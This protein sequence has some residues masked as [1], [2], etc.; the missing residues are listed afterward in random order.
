EERDFIKDG[1]W[2]AGHGK[3]A[4]WLPIPNS[5]DGLRGD[6]ESPAD[7]QGRGMERQIRQLERGLGRHAHSRDDRRKQLRMA[8]LRSE[9]GRRH[10]GIRSLL[11]RQAVLPR[12]CPP[13]R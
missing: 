10:E 12:S 1:G 7:V 2:W 6:V 13:Q 4:G 5:K 11:V 8:A 3:R 9:A